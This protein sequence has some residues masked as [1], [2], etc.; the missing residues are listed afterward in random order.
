MQGGQREEGGLFILQG[1]QREEGG[2]FRVEEL[3]KKE[4]GLYLP[5]YPSALVFNNT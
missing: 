2:Y 3:W 4:V 1:G 5:I